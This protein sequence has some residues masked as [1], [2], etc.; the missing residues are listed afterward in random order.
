MTDLTDGLIFLGE[1]K[2]EVA[3]ENITRPRA[4]VGFF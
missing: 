1:G 2:E 4:I 3:P